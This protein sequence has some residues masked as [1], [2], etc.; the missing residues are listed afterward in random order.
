M[1]IVQPPEPFRLRGAKWRLPPAAQVNKSGWTGNSK[2]VGLPGAQCWTVSGQFVTIV[3]ADRAKPWKS[4][5][6]LV[7]QPF[8]AFPIIA[9]E[10][11]QTLA[12]NPSAAAGGGNADT[13]PLTGLPPSETVLGIGDMMTVPLPSGR[14]RLVCLSAPLISDEFGHAVASFGP[15]LG[16]IPAAGAT[17]EIGEPFAMVRMASDTPA[18]WDVDVGQTYDF[19]LSVE[20]AR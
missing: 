15:E 19:P 3:G 20:E 17:V 12:A 8:R 2:G 14:Y 9:V 16:E 6:T 18:G 5:F 7:S 1:I 10:A 11:R 4:F 13:M